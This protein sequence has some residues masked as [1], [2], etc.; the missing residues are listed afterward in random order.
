MTLRLGLLSTASINRAILGGARVAD[1]VEVVAV[2]SRE[3][4]RARGFAAEH[5]VGGVHGSYE[6]L[7][8]DPQVDAV[9]GFETDGQIARHDLVVL[10][11]D[12]AAWPPYHAAPIVA[13]RFAS[14]AGAAF[15]P[16]LDGPCARGDSD[17]ARWAAECGT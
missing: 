8:E 9:Y 15:A 3:A 13:E 2:A 5:G 6:A 16:T 11:D 12:R 10:R 7:L 14:R 17:A 4:E 1:G